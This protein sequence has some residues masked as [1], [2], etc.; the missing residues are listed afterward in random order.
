MTDLVFSNSLLYINLAIPFAIALYFAIT[1]KH[2]TWVEFSAQ[3]ALTLT[4]L[5]GFFYIGYASQDIIT[6]CYNSGKVDKI[7]YKEEWKELVHYQEAYSCGTSK[8]P[9]TCYRPATRI[10]DHPDHFYLSHDFGTTDISRE[11]YNL[12][13]SEFGESQ[14]DSH[15]SGQISIG[16]GRTFESAPNVIIPVVDTQSGINYVYA[17]KHNIIKSNKY[18][19][20]EKKYS[21]ELVPY[22]SLYED[23]HGNY[24]FDRVFNGNLINFKDRAELNKQLYEYASIMGKVKEVNPIIY[25]TS[26]PERDFAYVVKGFYKDAH[27]N[28]AVLVVSVNKDGSINWIDSFGFTKSAEFFV[29]NRNIDKNIS[30]LA[31]NFTANINMYWKRTP[32]EDY[33]YLSGEIDLSLN[34]EIFL[35][36]LNIV[37]SFVLFRVFLINGESKGGWRNSSENYGKKFWDFVPEKYRNFIKKDKYPN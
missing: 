34:F 26:A 29:Y 21:K 31:K 24:T 16:D 1:N 28:D 2:Y 5:I 3:V 15:H 32:M 10:D 36:L 8:Q 22:P 17:S 23:K 13:K 20:L 7:V 4:I 9:M 30:S 14:T 25:F 11:Q 12:A 37:G 33:K 19:D 18:L 27:K 6:T 35:I